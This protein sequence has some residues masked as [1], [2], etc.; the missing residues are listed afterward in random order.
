MTAPDPRRRDCVTV[1][2]ELCRLGAHELLSQY[3]S[4]SLSPVEVTEAT[5]ERIAALN[6]RINALYFV[7]A[8]GAC[9]SARAGFGGS[10]CST[11]RTSSSYESRSAITSFNRA[12]E[13]ARISPTAT[14]CAI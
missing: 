3:R 11:D 13:S 2:D 12:P 7:D 1:V 9:A 10:T 14:E 8:G 4:R 6:P 5:L